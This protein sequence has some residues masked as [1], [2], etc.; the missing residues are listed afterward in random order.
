[1]ATNAQIKPVERATDTTWDEWLQFMDGIGATELD[2]KAI[3]LKVYEE[4]EG[5]IDQP[6]CHRHQ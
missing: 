1:M 2:H 3:A 6:G 5:S 4:L